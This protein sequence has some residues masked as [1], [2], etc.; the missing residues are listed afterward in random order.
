MN[1]YFLSKNV[2]NVRIRMPITDELIQEIL[3]QRFLLIKRCVLF[4]IQ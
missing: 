2:L 1:Y 3:L 4:L